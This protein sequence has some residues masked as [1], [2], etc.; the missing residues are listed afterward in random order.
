MR[1]ENRVD[2]LL[3]KGQS[4]ARRSELDP[5]GYSY[6][7]LCKA[8]RRL[9]GKNKIIEP[10]QGFFVL[11]PPS[12]QNGGPPPSYFIDPL[13][14]Y[15]DRDYYVGLVSSAASYGSAHHAPQVFQ[16]VISG[17]R[18]N[19]DLERGRIVFIKNNAEFRPNMFET[20]KVETGYY[21]RSNPSVTL[22]DLTYYLRHAG[23][24]TTSAML[25]WRHPNESNRNRCFN[26]L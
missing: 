17:I 7:G 23:G 22:A 1:L 6:S 14:N 15:E 9:K 8:L 21:V 18:K 25:R 20:K 5:G 3:S 2:E 10:V 13:M 11:V 24:S 12:Y 26:I 19:I 4:V 16:V